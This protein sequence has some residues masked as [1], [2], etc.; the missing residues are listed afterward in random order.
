MREEIGSHNVLDK[1]NLS[2]HSRASHARIPMPGSTW[3]AAPSPPPGS[4]GFLG[5]NRR[6][7]TK[8]LWGAA[9]ERPYFHHGLYTTLRE[10]TLAHS[11]EALASRQAFV[12][13]TDDE[14]DPVIEFLKSLQ[15]LPP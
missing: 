4:A 11:G 8:K 14:R 13:L 6:F 1:L 10:T 3:R 2:N 5:G 7:L 15:V 12:A 9:N